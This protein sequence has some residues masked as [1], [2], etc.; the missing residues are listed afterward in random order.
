[1]SKKK[2]EKKSDIELLKE[3][4]KSISNE[5]VKKLIKDRKENASRSRP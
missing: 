5:T 2:E 1:M 4:L 3:R